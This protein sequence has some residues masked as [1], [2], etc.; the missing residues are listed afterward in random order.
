MRGHNIH[1]YAELIKIVLNCQQILTFSSSS[2]VN[3]LFIF[4]EEI[5]EPLNHLRKRNKSLQCTRK[6]CFSC[7]LCFC[8]S[9]LFHFKVWWWRWWRHTHS[10]RAFSQRKHC[11]CGTWSQTRCAESRK[12]HETSLTDSP[13]R[14]EDWGKNRSP[15]CA[16]RCEGRSSK[17][18]E[19]VDSFQKQK[20][21]TVFG[22]GFRKCFMI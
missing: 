17:C 22:K 9:C 8:T 16:V 6:P 4:K 18:I 11:P 7:V 10:Y 3:T 14:G 2:W 21:R 19:Y 1:L 5:F 13:G 20:N 15:V 12:Y